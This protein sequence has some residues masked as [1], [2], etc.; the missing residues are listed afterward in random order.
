MT[1]NHFFLNEISQ[2]FRKKKTKKQKQKK[3]NKKKKKKK[4]QKKTK[5]KWKID[6]ERAGCLRQCPNNIRNICVCLMIEIRDRF[7]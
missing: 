3:T 2:L 7:E 6:A 4:K 1:F 5:K